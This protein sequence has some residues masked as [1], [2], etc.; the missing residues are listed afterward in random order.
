MCLEHDHV[1]DWKNVKIFKSEPHVD[2]YHTM[3]HFLINQKWNN[4][5][6]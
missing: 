6:I 3:K 1:I 5:M 2:R 4:S